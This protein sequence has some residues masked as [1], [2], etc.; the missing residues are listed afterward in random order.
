[1]MDFQP[2]A[3]VD[4][5]RAS[6]VRDTLEQWAWYSGGLLLPMEGCAR[7]WLQS[8]ANVP[9]GVV[10]PAI[11]TQ[12]VGTLPVSAVIQR[13]HD[14]FLL[15]GRIAHINHYFQLSG[16]WQPLVSAIDESL[17]MREAV[18]LYAAGFHYQDTVIYD[19]YRRRIAMG[20]PVLR[21]KVLLDRPELIDA[22][23]ARFVELFHSVKT[24]GLHF[25]SDYADVV[26]DRPGLPAWRTRWIEWSEREIGVAIGADG[27]FYR[28]PGGQHR[29][30]I[31]RVLGL[32]ALPVQVRLVH[33][34]WMARQPEKT[35]WQAIRRALD[36]AQD[37][38]A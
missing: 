33:A 28:L 14:W 16:N 23:F 22:Y 19:Q 31:A 30:A 27:S 21:G 12:L 36:E 4:V 17:V 29:T 37:Y 38:A 25:L 8:G 35:P 32:P 34:E 1:M 9:L 10:L 20:K 7:R 11:G 15:D 2:L 5:P 26:A 3:G 6:R 24:N 18:Q 13:L